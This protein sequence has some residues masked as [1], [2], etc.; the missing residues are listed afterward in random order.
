MRLRPILAF[1]LALGVVWPGAA[2]AQDYPT[3]VVRIIVRA[4]RGAGA[5]TAFS[6]GA[7]LSSADATGAGCRS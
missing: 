7:G 2:T 1:L 5:D 4:T 3:K 6:S